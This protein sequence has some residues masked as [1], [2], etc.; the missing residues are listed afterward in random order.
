MLNHADEI[1]VLKS[2]VMAL[3]A[4]LNIWRDAAIA[5]DAYANSRAPAGTTTELALCQQLQAAIQK[6]T[7]VRISAI[8]AARA[9]SFQRTA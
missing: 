5:E 1:A 7:P 4:E 9:V 3:E 6:R 2:H 8:L